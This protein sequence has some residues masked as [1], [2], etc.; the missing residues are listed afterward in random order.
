MEKRK[1]YLMSLVLLAVCTVFG[2]A[3]TY[4][5]VNLPNLEIESSGYY[6]YTPVFQVNE[7]GPLK[8]VVRVRA[9]SLFADETF[10]FRVQLS[11]G[12]TAHPS[13]W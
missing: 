3:S 7:P 6:F 2:T 9:Y 1:S 13:G 4:A 5:S 12:T 8:I 10:T 11:K